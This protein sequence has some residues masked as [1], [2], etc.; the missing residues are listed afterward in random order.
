MKDKLALAGTTA[1]ALGVTG[2]TFFSLPLASYFFL[3]LLSAGFLLVWFLGK[4]DWY[5]F[6]SMLLFFFAVGCI[7]LDL[8]PRALLCSRH[9]R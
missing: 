8:T 3:I 2:A 9:L 1:F 4:K 6:P 5:L 7:R